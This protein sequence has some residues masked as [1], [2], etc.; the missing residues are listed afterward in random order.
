MDAQKLAE[1]RQRRVMTIRELAAKAGV[2][3][4]TVNELER[5]RRNAHPGTIRKL[6]AAL[7]VEAEELVK[8]NS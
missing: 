4:A 6:A 5:G 1:L 7:G 3:T 2:A 8:V